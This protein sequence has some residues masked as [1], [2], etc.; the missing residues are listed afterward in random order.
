L[1]VAQLSKE[2]AAAFPFQYSEIRES[3]KRVGKRIGISGSAEDD[4]RGYFG[5]DEYSMPPIELDELHS[6][7]YRRYQLKRKK[8]NALGVEVGRSR[9]AVLSMDRGDRLACNQSGNCL[10]GCN[11]KSLYSAVDDLDLLRSHSNFKEI[12]GLYV[13]EVVRGQGVWSIFGLL[14]ET[15]EAFKYSAKYIVLAAGTLASTRLI[16]NAIN[17]RNPVR[18]FS[19][20]TA[21]FM[22]FAPNKN[23]LREKPGLD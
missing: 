23:R 9:V 20:P 14:A 15:K 2:E 1:W 12:S 18:M 8:I 16:L 13:D 21:A 22:V 6:Y 17:L 7:F 5:V 10:W 11:R 3:Y 4:L 19:S